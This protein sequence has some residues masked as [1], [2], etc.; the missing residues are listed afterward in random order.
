MILP[1]LVVF[2]GTVCEALTL[3]RLGASL[4]PRMDA[5]DSEAGLAWANTFNMKT[6]EPYNGLNPFMRVGIM[7]ICLD[8]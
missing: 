8:R 1:S 7:P 5:G 4:D 3:P 6:S 2:G